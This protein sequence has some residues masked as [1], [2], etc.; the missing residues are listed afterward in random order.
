MEIKI[1]FSLSWMHQEQGDWKNFDIF[2]E[3]NVIL[4]PST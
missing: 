1:K 3:R 4:Y 2:F